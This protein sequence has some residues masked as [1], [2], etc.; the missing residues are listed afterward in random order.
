MGW[1]GGTD[2]GTV[3]VAWGNWHRW[4]GL[5]TDGNGHV[6]N[7]DGLDIAGGGTGTVDDRHR[8]QLAMDWAQL[9]MNISME[10]LKMDRT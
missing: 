4:D 8:Q 1:T 5:G 9:R 2:M 10:Q 6:H 7:W 3:G